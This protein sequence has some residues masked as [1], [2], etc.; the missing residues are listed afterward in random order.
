M[1]CTDPL[2]LIICI[3]NRFRITK[4]LFRC[5]LN[6]FEPS[7]WISTG[8]PVLESGPTT[9]TLA[10]EHDATTAMSKASGSFYALSVFNGNI[11]MQT[12]KEVK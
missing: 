1:F 11:K 7:G 9:A 10:A 4:V 12:Y 6:Y 5:F 8:R 3:G 2:F